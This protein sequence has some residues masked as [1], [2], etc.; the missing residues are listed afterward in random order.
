[1]TFSVIIA[2]LNEAEWIG[3]CVRSVRTAGGKPEIILGSQPESIQR[4]IL[5]DN[6]AKLYRLDVP[7]R[8]VGD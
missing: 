1:M 6:A 2:A 8:S 4:K 3:D 7:T 5:C